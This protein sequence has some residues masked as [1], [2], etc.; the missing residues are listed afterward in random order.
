MLKKEFEANYKKYTLTFSEPAKTSRNT[1]EEKPTFFLTLK[2]PET[3]MVGLGECS[4]IPDL[5]VEGVNDIEA[6]LK[7]ICLTTNLNEHPQNFLGALQELPAVKFGLEMALKDFNNG[8]HRILFDTPFSRGDHVLPINGLIW[9]GSYESMKQQIDEKISNGFSCIKM[10]I[11]AINFEEELKLIQYIKST[12][13]EA[14]EIRVDANGAFSPVDALEKLKL[15]SKEG[16]HS[17]EQPIDV[18][19]WQEMKA[20]CKNTPVPIALDEE[21]IGISTTHKKQELLKAI[22]PQ[23]LILKPSLLGGFNECEEWVKLANQYNIDWWVTS[24][25]ESNI[26]LNAIAQWA[27]YMEVKRPQGLG[28][29]QIYNN[30]IESPLTIQ[31]GHLIYDPSQ[32]WETTKVVVSL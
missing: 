30:N 25:L 3:E 9:M 24:A 6:K 11:G 31:D 19:Q 23:Y 21:L 2:D 28:T 27:S 22:E 20:L 1:L 10:K 18:N 17:I 26:G 13:T 4:P 8:G 15:L 5:S 32:P 7:E 14:I 29:G 12:Y 16:V